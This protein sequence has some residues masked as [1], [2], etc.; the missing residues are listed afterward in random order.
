VADSWVLQSS[1]SS[2][3]QTD[4]VAKVVSKSGQNARA[5]FRFDLPAIPAGCQVT[6]AQLRHYAGGSTNGR[7]LQALRINAAWTENGV[8]WS[9]QP[10]TTGPAATT[11]SGTGWRQ[12]NVLSQVQGMYSTANHGF[13]VRD[14]TEGGG[15]QEQ[16]L[17]TREKAPDR[18]PE[19]VITFG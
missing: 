17:H 11:S 8:T 15:G 3:Y 14:A 2:N 10:A 6:G 9:N 7:T 1:P 5:L 19:L 4:A 12:W 18:P 16:Q 13:L